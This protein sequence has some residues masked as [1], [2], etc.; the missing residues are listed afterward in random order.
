PGAAVRG[1]RQRAVGAGGDGPGDRPLA[2]LRVRGDEQRPGGPGG[3]RRSQRPA[4]RRPHVDR[5]RGQAQGRGRRRS[6]WLRRRPGRGRVR[7]GRW[8]PGRPGGWRRPALLTGTAGA[9]VR[10]DAGGGA[11]SA[12]YCANRFFLSHLTIAPRD[13]SFSAGRLRP[14]PSLTTSAA[15]R[16]QRGL[17][18][19]GGVPNGFLRAYP[20]PP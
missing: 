8:R 9:S 17:L 14:V 12:G 3:Y 2:R 18:D 6:W 15:W 16:R 4:S 7:W 13:L 11:S 5:Q 1:A 19:T 20:A 10:D